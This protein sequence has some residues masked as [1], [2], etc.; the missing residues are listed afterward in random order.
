MTAAE[1]A[2]W[3]LPNAFGDELVGWDGWDSWKGSTLPPPTGHTRIVYGPHLNLWDLEQGSWVKLVGGVDSFV[4]ACGPDDIVSVP[5]LRCATDIPAWDFDE[6]RCADYKAHVEIIKEIAPYV[7]GIMLGNMGP[8]LVAHSGGGV[9]EHVKEA[10]VLAVKFAK[11]VERAGGIPYFGTVD[12]SLL[13]DCY[14]GGHLRDII[15]AIGAIQICFCGYSLHPNAFFDKG[16]VLHKGQVSRQMWQEGE[17]PGPRF[18]DYIHSVPMWS[19]L[20][21]M[22][23]YEAGNDKLLKE[24]GFVRG[25]V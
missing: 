6:S 8:E 10:A 22:D 3:K 2:V 16:L 13:V 15:R 11:I 20:N 25:C 19:D 21:W 12:W 4:G 17:A 18:C 9:Y 7:K 14:N 5:L 23:G 1:A 24:M